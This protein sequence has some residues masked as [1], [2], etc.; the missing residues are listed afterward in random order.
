ASDDPSAA[1]PLGQ[2]SNG[3]SAADQALALELV[4]RSLELQGQ[5]PV[6]GGPGVNLIRL[7]NSLGC[8]FLT[9]GAP[10]LALPAAAGWRPCLI[11]GQGPSPW[12]GDGEAPLALERLGEGPVLLQ[13]FVRGNPFRGRADGPDPWPAVIHQLQAAGRLAGLAVYG[14]PYAWQALQPLLKP[15]VPAAW[16]PGQMALAQGELLGRLGFGPK[17]ATAVDFTD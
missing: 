10:A 1:A 6:R 11:D 2:L 16:S 12:S 7:D 14:S 4:Q 13:L 15:G 9:A 8:P 5:G 17:P 3:P